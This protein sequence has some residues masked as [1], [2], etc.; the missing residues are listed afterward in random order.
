MV[1]VTSGDR[2]ATEHHRVGGGLAKDLINKGILQDIPIFSRDKSEQ[3]AE[4]D[5]R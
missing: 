2:G 3:R 4:E 5:E 1:V